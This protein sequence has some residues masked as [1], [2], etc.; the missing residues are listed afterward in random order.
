MVHCDL[1]T[2][3]GSAPLGMALAILYLSAY[4]ADKAL[5]ETVVQLVTHACFGRQW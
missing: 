3:Y 4:M 5:Y 1:T 2:M